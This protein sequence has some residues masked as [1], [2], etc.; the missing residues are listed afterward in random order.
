MVIHS[1]IIDTIKSNPHLVNLW[2]M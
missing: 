2:I 1:D